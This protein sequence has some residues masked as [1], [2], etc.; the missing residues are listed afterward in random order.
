MTENQKDDFVTKELAKYSLS[1]AKIAELRA[2]FMPLKV[3]GIQDV[4]NYDACK[5]AHQE[6]RAI[7]INIEDKRKELKSKSLDFGRKVDTEAKR[8][9]GHVLEIETHLLAQRKVVEDEAKRIENERRAAAQREEERIKREEEERLEGIRQAQAAKEKEL[10]GKQAAIDEEIRKVKRD[11]EILEADKQ[12]AI[13]I[14]EAKKR[15]AE[16]A[17]LDAENE[18]KRKETEAK[19]KAEREKQV[20][21]DAQ[22]AEADKILADQRAERE[23]EFKA[24][25]AKLA[26]ERAEREAVEALLASLVECPKCHHKFTPDK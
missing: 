14:E 4:K 16:Q 13:E 10:A 1:D 18:A 11:K 22:K 26:K 21:L 24:S 9:T 6:V 7:R 8:L 5:T 20:A 2:K 25:E 3:A 19:E 23:K 15:A 17:K 12:K